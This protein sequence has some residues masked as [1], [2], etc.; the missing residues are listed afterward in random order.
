MPSWI[1][2]AMFQKLKLIELSITFLIS[3]D[4]KASINL[5]LGHLRSQS[6]PLITA[7]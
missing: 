2:G 4:Q 7:N 1:T 3:L 5:Y 6:D